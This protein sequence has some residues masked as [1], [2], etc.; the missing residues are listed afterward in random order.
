M[1]ASLSVPTLSQV[2]TLDTGYL[3]EAAEYWTHTANLWAQAFAEVHARISTPGGTPWWGQA[4]AAAQERAYLD[5]V[6]VRKASDQLQEA[7]SLAIRGD[8]Q[9]QACRQ[10]VLE[11]VH[12]AHAEGFEVGEL[13]S[14]TDHSYGGSAEFRA[15]RQVHAQGHASFIRHRL[16]TL[17]ATD[18]QLT[19]NITAATYGIGSLNF[20]EAPNPD[21]TIVDDDKHDTVQPVDHTV[22]HDGGPGVLEDEPWH[23]PWDPPP[24]P[25]SAPGGGR[26]DIDRDH[27][28]PS[29]P[30]GGPPTGPI[31]QPKP[32]RKDFS[33]SPVTGPTS[34]LQDVVATPPNGWGVQPAWT[35]QE[36]YRFRL[37]GE[38]FDGASDHIRWIQRDGNWYQATWVG[39]DFEAEHVTALVPH[40]SAGGYM[41]VIRD[42][43]HWNPIGIKDIYGIQVDNPR[44]PLYL[45][46]PFGD[47]YE[48]PTNRPRVVASP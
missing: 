37:V 3:R 24:P 42:Q 28:Y 13:Y 17:M 15:A 10:G 7:A 1:P 31:T 6:R 11:A 43:N 46:N 41:P 32:W 44:L 19:T 45:P 2:K 21:D 48:L 34:G 20:P 35:M 9:L 40:N 4:A 30:G 12:E 47:Q 16:G 38:G 26:W 33:E 29:G 25:D 5:L 22:K 18:H 23:Y 14:V 39:Y 8:E 36:E 27:P